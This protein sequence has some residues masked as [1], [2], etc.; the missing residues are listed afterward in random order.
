MGTNTM[1]DALPHPEAIQTGAASPDA[2]WSGQ[3][4]D[5]RLRGFVTNLEARVPGSAGHSRRVAAD[6]RVVAD[7]LGCDERQVAA[8]GR[9]AGVHDVGKIIVPA[10]IL[11]KPGAL[12]PAEYAE[13]KRHATFGARLVG[14]VGDPELTAIV[15]HHHERLDGSGFPDGLCGGAIPLGARIVAVCDAYDRLTRPR[16]D[17]E[18]LPPVAAL[19]LL[20]D[21]S[22]AR[23]DP[24]V[25]AAF[26]A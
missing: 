18:A 6:S 12:T 16:P 17:R 13:A 21:E 19:R 2:P 22:G 5:A 20:Q 3:A 4:W 1:L 8:V 14:A 10:A 26:A 25:V 15:R 7:R 24:A 11:A 9:A 23:F